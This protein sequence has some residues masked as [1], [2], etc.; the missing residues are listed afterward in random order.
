MT[1]E[2]KPEIKRGMVVVAHPDDAEFG[3]AGTV[4]KWA[5]EGVEMYFVLCTDGSK[6]SS[7]PNMTPEELVTIRRQEQVEAARELG[8]KDVEFLGY[9]DAYVQHTRVAGHRAASAS[10]SRT[11]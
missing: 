3:C 2:N 5:S 6:G 8:V 4:A 11:E 9:P 7:D 1:E 10:T